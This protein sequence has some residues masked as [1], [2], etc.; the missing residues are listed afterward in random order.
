MAAANHPH[1]PPDIMRRLLIAVLVAAVSPAAFAQGQAGGPILTLD[2]AV[3]LALRNN[4]AHLQALS[5]QTRQGAALRS[6][7]GA[8]LPQVSSSFSASFREGGSEVFGG[9]EF[10]ASSDRLSSGYSLGLQASYSGASLLAPRVEKANLTAAEADVT[11]SA[12]QTRWQVVTQYLNVLQA[13]ARVALQDTLLANSQAQLELNRAREQVGA[14]TSLE[15]RR[16]EVQVGQARVNLLRDRNSVEIELLRLFQQMGV[17]RVDSARLTTTFPVAEPDLQ[18]PE[19]LGMAARANPSLN[20]ARAREDAAQVQVAQAR[21]QWIPSISLSTGFSGNALEE[22]NIE[23]SI[24]S[25]MASTALRRRGCLTNDSIRVGSGLAAI[26]CDGP[27][28]QFTDADAQAIRSANNSF[29]FSFTRSPLQYSLNLSLPIFN[30]FRREQQIQNA[31]LARNDARYQVRAQELQMNTEVTSAYRNLLTQYQTVRLQEQ[32][33]AASQQALDL[34]QERYRVGASTF[35]EV[36]QARADFE[37]AGNQL[38]NAIYDFH[39]AYAEL[40]RAVGRPL[41]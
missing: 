4:P 8:W 28:Y 5:G 37:Q 26:G 31:Q 29:P 32:N 13:Q 20:A 3:S 41:R 36:T 38:I 11:R 27:A 23:P 24:A 18:L 7:Y 39:K 9:L 34:A 21:S 22:T 12:A 10:G 40:E 6:A 1:E 14:T 33:R 16:A 19:L 2:E 15:V 35:I 30:G 25:A 17:D